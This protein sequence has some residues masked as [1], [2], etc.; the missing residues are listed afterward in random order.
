MTSQLITTATIR[1]KKAKEAVNS[2]DLFENTSE[3]IQEAWK[4]LRRAYEATASDSND[5]KPF[6]FWVLDQFEHR[7]VEK[8][9]RLGYSDNLGLLTSYAPSAREY[10]GAESW[11]FILFFNFIEQGRARALNYIMKNRDRFSIDQL[12]EEV[13]RNRSRRIQGKAS[14]RS[15]FQPADFKACGL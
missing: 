5:S 6:P 4:E 3:H 2:P 10:F 9:I 11:R 15:E 8:I 13:C 14:A 12:Y 7:H 1:V